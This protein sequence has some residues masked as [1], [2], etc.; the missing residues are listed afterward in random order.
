MNNKGDKRVDLT[1]GEEGKLDL[2]QLKAKSIDLKS[3]GELSARDISRVISSLRRNQFVK[4][5][6]ASKM[7]L[8]DDQVAMIVELILRNDSITALNLSGNMISNNALFLIDSLSS[9]TSLKSL[10]LSNNLI[11]HHAI[12]K[13]MQIAITASGLE[14]LNLSGNKLTN[15]EKDKLRESNKQS[16]TK[17]L[18]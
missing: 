13:K 2:S 9:N 14:S 3:L 15:I 4:I 18:F 7:N 8:S 16:K 1:Y 6:D 10:D 17:I 5:L 12:D 11:P